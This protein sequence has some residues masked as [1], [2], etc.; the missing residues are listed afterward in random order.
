MC[1][2]EIAR[3][4]LSFQNTLFEYF[5]S[6]LL[7]KFVPVAENIYLFCFQRNTA[8]QEAVRKKTGSSCFP[9]NQSPQHLTSQNLMCVEWTTWLRSLCNTFSSPVQASSFNF[10][11][12]FQVSRLIVGMPLPFRENRTLTYWGWFYLQV[13]KEH[14]YQIRFLHWFSFPRLGYL[15]LNNTAL[16]TTVLSRLSFLQTAGP[17][18]IPAI[19][20]DSHLDSWFPVSNSHEDIFS[21]QNKK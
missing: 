20:E 4:F 11:F 8:W 6:C 12:L 2:F 3:N 9:L 19:N 14:F 5:Y 15:L 10:S 7:K 18:P 1:W 16:K 17:V 13:P 21:L